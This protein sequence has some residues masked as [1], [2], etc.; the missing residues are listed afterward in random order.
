MSVD[1]P[2]DYRQKF[3]DISSAVVKRN[4][5]T[6]SPLCAPAMVSGIKLIMQFFDFPTHMKKERL[7]IM[8][9]IFPL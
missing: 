5:G 1:G 2:I 4:D 6:T 8:L 9:P 7:K 3:W